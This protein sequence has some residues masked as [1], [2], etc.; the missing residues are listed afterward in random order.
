MTSISQLYELTK[1]RFCTKAT[2][3]LCPITRAALKAMPAYEFRYQLHISHKFRYV[4][5]GNP[6]TGGST[7]KSALLELEIRD[8]NL[9]LNA[10]ERQAFNSDSSPL[11]STPPFWP[12][13]TLSDLLKSGYRFITFVRSPYTRLSSCYINK[14]INKRDDIHKTF[15]NQFGKLPVD[16]HDF[17]SK[18]CTQLDY[19]MNP[20]WRPQYR[21][22]HYNDIQYTSIGRFENFPID[23]RRTFDVLGVKNQHIPTIRHLNKTDESQKDL[24]VYSKETAHMVYERYRLD[25]ELFGYPQALDDIR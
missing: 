8:T 25:F 21:Q 17:I 18:I 23:F 14:F 2:E 11:K 10:L 1:E 6:K 13:Q 4:Y 15:F 5:V 19:E 9:R 7:L 22:I 20:H 12:H 16:F 24:A 3:A